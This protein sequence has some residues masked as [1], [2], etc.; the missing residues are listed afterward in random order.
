M[1]E[2]MNVD[3]TESSGENEIIRYSTRLIELTIERA[4][5]SYLSYDIILM[6][7]IFFLIFR[8]HIRTSK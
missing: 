7:K 5:G 3:Q 6:N 4:L 8:C 1:S 2:E